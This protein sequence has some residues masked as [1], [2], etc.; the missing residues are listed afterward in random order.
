MPWESVDIGFYQFYDPGG[1]VMCQSLV[2]SY[3]LLWSIK[4]RGAE[5]LICVRVLN[6]DQEEKVSQWKINLQK[7][8][9]K[10]QD[11]TTGSSF[12]FG[13]NKWR[14]EVGRTKIMFQ[15]HQEEEIG[16][17]NRKRSFFMAIYHITS[18]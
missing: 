15:G 8:E 3:A 14:A 13:N 9:C 6:K 16:H 10:N 2:K 11:K 7:E 4:W 18:F 5:W 1:W 12:E 17:Q